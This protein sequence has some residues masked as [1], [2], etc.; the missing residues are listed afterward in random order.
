MNNT[1]TVFVSY[2]KETKRHYETESF[3]EFGNAIVDVPISENGFSADM[4]IAT[5]IVN[6]EKSLCRT[7]YEKVFVISWKMLG[8]GIKYASS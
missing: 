6:I 2:W 8:V 1:M 3:T 5:D 7:D 4:D